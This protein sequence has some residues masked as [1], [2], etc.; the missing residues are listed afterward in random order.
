MLSDLL[1]NRATAQKL[2]GVISHQDVINV[3]PRKVLS[4]LSGSLLGR[5]AIARNAA[6]M[7]VCAKHVLVALN[8]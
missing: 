4:G 8:R 5:N 2:H 1:I 3:S 7:V 6:L